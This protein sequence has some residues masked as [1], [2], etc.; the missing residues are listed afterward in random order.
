MHEHNTYC[1]FAIRHHVL[2]D[3]GASNSLC[4]V[5]WHQQ[6]SWKPTKQNPLPPDLKPFRFAGYHLRPMYAACLICEVTLL[7]NMKYLFRQ[8]VFVLAPTPVP[9]LV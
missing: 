2:M 6:T 3:T 7:E 1:A 8:V 9:F 4:S 5:D